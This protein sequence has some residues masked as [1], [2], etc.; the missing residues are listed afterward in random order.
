MG[1]TLLSRDRTCLAV[2]KLLSAANACHLVEA[3]ATS[4]ALPKAAIT[5]EQP[6]NEECRTVNVPS[7]SE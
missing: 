2:S 7:V 5:C 4:I 6:Q 3:V 1:Q